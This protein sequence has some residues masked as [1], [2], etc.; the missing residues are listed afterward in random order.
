MNCFSNTKFWKNYLQFDKVSNTSS[1]RG[2]VDAV[3]LWKLLT[4]FPKQNILEI[5]CYQGLTAGLF[6]DSVNNV[7]VTC[8]DIEDRLDIFRL[9]YKSK[10]TQFKFILSSSQSIKNLDQTYD[11]I[12]IDG[13]HSFEP[14]WCDI[15]LS[16][17]HLKPSGILAL[18]DYT[19]PGVAKAIKN[20]Y[21]IN[22]GW[23]PFMQGPQTQYWHYRSQDKNK[24]LDNCLLDPIGKFIFLENIRDTHNNTILDAKSVRVLTDHYHMF[25]QALKMYNL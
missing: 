21:N 20:L 8:V 18:D 5:G 17:Q 15:Q 19:M 25:D 12:F 14:C 1:M 16:L 10:L 11:M 13:D 9:N 4:E 7:K 2:F 3:L 24:F 6:F 23:I 22:S